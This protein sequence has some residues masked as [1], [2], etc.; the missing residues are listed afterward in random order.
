MRLLLLG[1]TDF[2]GRSIAEA[3]RDR[4]WDVTVLHRGEHPPPPGVTVLHGDRTAPDGL[5]ALATGTWDAV[6]DTWS[7]APRVVRDAARLLVGRVGRYAFVSSRS[8]Y[9]WPI[10]AGLD[11]DGPLVAGDPD[12]EADDYA[13]DKRGAE[14]AV[15]REF[16]PERTLLLR[17]GLILGPRENCGRLPWWLDRISRGGPLLAPGPRDTPLQYID[18]RDLAIWTLDA[19]EA[20]LHGPFNVV[21]P[22]GHTT[23]GDLLDACVA[24]TGSDTALVWTGPDTV[25]AAG[26]S[27]WS[28]LPIWWPP[29]GELHDAL[30][31]GD[32]TRALATGLACRPVTETVADTWTWL[33]E[34]APAPAAP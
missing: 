5:S 20:G 32:V 17:A 8:V 1:G 25:A 24:V 22:P 10:P 11:E 7:S 27:P 19:L 4:G 30:H 16:G 33:R 9:A 13:A 3:A 31:R 21:S 6:V 26:V 34:T 15:L 18:A 28:D 29:G 14:L 12:A 2:A 23:M